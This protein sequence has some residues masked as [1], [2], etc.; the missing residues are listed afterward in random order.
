MCI[1][2]RCKRA[3]YKGCFCVGFR[4][5]ASRRLYI[6]EGRRKTKTRFLFAYN[7]NLP[8]PLLPPLFRVVLRRKIYRVSRA[9]FDVV[10]VQAVYFRFVHLRRNRKDVYKRQRPSCIRLFFS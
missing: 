4:A 5:D 1:R 6:L 8:L 9:V 10:C 3:Q 2:D 7:R